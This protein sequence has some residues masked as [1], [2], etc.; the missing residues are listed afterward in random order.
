V[1]RGQIFVSISE[2]RGAAAIAERHLGRRRRS[3]ARAPSGSKHSSDQV[4]G[5]A[6]RDAPA[7]RRSL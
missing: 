7:R 3:G 2:K 5:Q 6:V 1:P 4:R